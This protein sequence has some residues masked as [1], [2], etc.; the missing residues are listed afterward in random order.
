MTDSGTPSL[1]ET[2]AGWLRAGGRLVLESLARDGVL[3]SGARLVG[4]P[5]PAAPVE[6]WVSALAAQ[7]RF[8]AAVLSGVTESLAEGD[9][10]MVLGR[11]R[12]LHAAR[13]LLLTSD[14]ARPRTDLLALGME[15]L[16]AACGATDT[17][18]YAG[19]RRHPPG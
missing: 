16:Q 15:R 12:D 7:P 11:V 6:G 10:A 18:L 4:L 9:A 13:V 2:A 1:D 14:G 3:P 17:A 8:D 19:T 5:A